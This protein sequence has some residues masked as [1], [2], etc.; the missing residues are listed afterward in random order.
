MYILRISK[1]KK[2]LDNRFICVKIMN[3]F[4]D[5]KGNECVK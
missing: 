2:P 1:R 5:D 4:E 3:R